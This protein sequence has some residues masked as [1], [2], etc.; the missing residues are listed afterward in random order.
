MANFIFIFFCLGA[1]FIAARS[2]ALPRDSFKAVNA[3][4]VYFGL[5]ALA[6]RYI[7]TISWSLEMLVPALTPVVAWCGAWVFVQIYGKLRPIGPDTRAVMLVGCGLGNTGFFGYPIVIAFFG[8]DALS[9]ALVSDIVTVTLFCTL[10]IAT[11]LKAANQSAGGHTGFGALAKKMFTFPVFTTSLIVLPLSLVLDISAINPFVDLIVPTVAPLALFSIGLQF[12]FKD[13]GESMGHVMAGMLYR[14]I[15]SPALVLLLALALGA[16]GDTA[17]IS[18]FEAGT[19]T[20]VVVCVT[21]SQFNLN[22]RLCALMVAL[23]IVGALIVL[24][25]WYYVMQFIF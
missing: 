12:D 18:V 23:T 9:T 7:P 21:A 24:P 17:M 8:T 13:S 25:G 3:W 15:I 1:G 4:V 5:P 14:L 6:I 19:P 11:V 10:G 22:P 20:H 2:G 16:R